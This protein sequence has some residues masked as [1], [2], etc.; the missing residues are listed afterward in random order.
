MKKGL[1]NLTL[2]GLGVIS[3]AVVGAIDVSTTGLPLLSG[4]LEF[5]TLSKVKLKD[6]DFGDIM[7]DVVKGHLGYLTG[8]AIPFGIK[9][10]NEIYNFVEGVLK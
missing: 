6:T 7:G 5:A 1:E 8:V 4:Y 10:H 9:Y 2:F 3:G